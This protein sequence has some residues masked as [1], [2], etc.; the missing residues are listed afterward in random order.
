MMKK[1]KDK[2]KI[3]AKGKYSLKTHI[4]SLF[5]IILSMISLFLILMSFNDSKSL[6]ETLAKERINQ[7][8][9][10]IRLTFQK[11]TT[12]LFTSLNILSSS[13][14]AEQLRFDNKGQWV[15]TS[16]IILKNNPDI[17]SIYLGFDDERS[18]F[19]RSLRPSFMRSV[20]SA[21]KKAL[22]MMEINQKN[23]LQMQYFYDDKNH[24][25]ETKE[26]ESHFRP[27]QRAW[28]YSAPSNG[29]IYVTPAYTYHFINKRGISFSKRV[30][31]ANAVIAMDVT[32]HSFDL[33]L[34]S[35]TLANKTQIIIFDKN[36]FVIAERG[37]KVPPQKMEENRFPNTPL[38]RLLKIPHW[39]EMVEEIEFKGQTWV[40]NLVK[41]D[42]FKE[43][44]FWLAKAVPKN[45]LIR[46]A[47][48]SRN[49]QIVLTLILLLFGIG[50]ILWASEKIARRLKSLNDATF[51]IRNLNFNFTNLQMPES[52]IIEM[53]DLSDSFSIMSST[54]ARF[55][56][57]LQAVSK[58]ADFDYLL[59]DIVL[60]CQ[61]TSQADLVIMWSKKSNENE[62]ICVLAHYPSPLADSKIDFQNLVE[63]C[64]ELKNLNENKVITFSPNQK[65]KQKKRFPHALKRGWV[66]PLCDRN[67]QNIGH[68]LIGFNRTLKPE[69][70][71]KIH[72]IQAFLSF[73]SLITE[74][75]S[76]IAAQKALF[77]SLI[78]MLASA[79]DTKSPYTGGHCQ[80]V[81]ELTFMLAEAANQDKRAFPDFNLDASSREALHIAAWLHDCGKVTTPEYVV[82][83]A[84]KLETIYNRI[85]E[86]RTRFEVLKRDAKIRYWEQYHQG[87]TPIETLK[88]ELKKEEAA[89]DADFAFIAQ[90]NVGDI[91]MSEIQLSRMEKIGNTLWE[92]TMNDT[93]GLSCEELVRRSFRDTPPLPCKE[94]LLKDTS[95][96]E[97]HRSKKQKNKYT[98]WPFKIQIP[99]LQYNRGERHNLSVKKGTLT[100]EE[101]F[102]INDHI[103][104]TIIMLNKLP[105]PEHLKG[106]PSMAGAHH[107]KLNGLG[108]PMRLKGNEISFETR[109]MTI[110]D[111]FEALT[112]SDRPYKKA[113]SLHEA[114]HILAKMA[115]NNH[116]DLPLFRFFVEKKI[117]L[118]YA[119]RFLPK[120][121][122]DIVDEKE[123]LAILYS[124]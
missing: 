44:S 119:K 10:Q 87:K 9:E 38:H 16:N 115:K 5:F 36:K 103:V 116:I 45:E 35:L 43:Q 91:E 12:S 101:R 88:A 92:R 59:N 95:C 63:K 117:Y 85:H 13:D 75:R 74:N 109:I 18:V 97:I 112:A 67:N 73:V 61:K 65:D 82:D 80:R 76:H 28:F 64:P 23:G 123:I 118:Q 93:L 107:E 11:M 39:K 49:K 111:I 53:N 83:K 121:Q 8:E 29:Q 60:Q 71:N 122:H 102:I 15:E 34:H 27:T 56:A 25:L 17:L 79:I 4:A 55:L 3:F 37:L 90:C 81:P 54:L 31:K 62:N 68:V 106:I 124:K 105:Y 66:F 94:T 7:S 42:A 46:D 14:F 2:I 89:L 21:P 6:N 77:S 50:M 86:I 110:A 47:L 22:L 51:Q 41:I 69:Q 32:V 57:T 48:A 120:N 78:E 113:L 40:I 70:E 72:F 20:F 33:L 99:R 26:K 58:S 114:L 96:H 104:Q 98:H 108:Y 52:N 19:F 24:L 30:P 84:T 100:E 1:I